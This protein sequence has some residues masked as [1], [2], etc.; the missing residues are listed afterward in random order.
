MVSSPISEALTK[1]ACVHEQHVFLRMHATTKTKLVSRE[2][3]GVAST[4]H[5]RICCMHA[6]ARDQI[7]FRWEGPASAGVIQRSAS[8]LGRDG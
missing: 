8:C 3:E 5:A 1:S 4:V 6:C 2:K 7:F